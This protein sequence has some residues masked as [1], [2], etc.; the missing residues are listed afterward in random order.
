M[1]TVI[2]IGLFLTFGFLYQ[3]NA[4][5]AQ[6]EPTKVIRLEIDGKEV[7]RIYEVFFRLNAKLIKAKKTST[8]FIIPAELRNNEYLT[9]FISLGKHKLKFSDIHISKFGAEWIVGIDNKPFS[10]ENAYLIDIEE[11]AIKRVYYIHFVGGGLETVRLVM[12]K[13]K[14]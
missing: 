10:E 5:S 12:E 2:I 1:K 9:A 11:E 6:Y 13:N 8:G 3:A 7:K 14:K 4:Q